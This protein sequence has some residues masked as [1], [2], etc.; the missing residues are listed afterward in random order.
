MWNCGLSCSLQAGAVRTWKSRSL[1]H[2]TGAYTPYCASD[3]NFSRTTIPKAMSSASCPRWL[4]ANVKLT[5]R[6]TSGV[7]W[8]PC[9]RND[10]QIWPGEHHKMR[11]MSPSHRERRLWTC[12]D[13]PTLF[14]S[15]S[16]ARAPA[17][18][19]V[20]NTVR[21]TDRLQEPGGGVSGWRPQ[22][23]CVCSGSTPL[24]HVLEQQ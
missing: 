9:W 8:S 23:A 11:D 5:G 1:I 17:M 15:R 13:H 24:N 19:S 14:R 2:T 6:H 21:S 20:R 3:G 10:R 4:A 12:P 16:V 7:V 18:A 22:G